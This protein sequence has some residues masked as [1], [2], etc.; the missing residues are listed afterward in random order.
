MQTICHFH[1]FSLG[2]SVFTVFNSFHEFSTG[3]QGFFREFSVHWF[4]VVFGFHSFH[5]LWFWWSS[6]YLQIT[7]T[8]K[9]WIYGFALF[10]YLLCLQ[11]FVHLLKVKRRIYCLLPISCGEQAALHFKSKVAFNCFK[12]VNYFMLFFKL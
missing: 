8:L 12:F 3:F 5:H 9:T 7:F 1:L 6:E 11:A 10:C 2:F 4:S